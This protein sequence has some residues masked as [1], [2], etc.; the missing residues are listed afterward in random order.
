AGWCR[1]CL[2]HDE[3]ELTAGHRLLVEARDGWGGRGGELG[4]WLRAAALDLHSARGDVQTARELAGDLRSG[5]A[6]LAVAAARTELRA[7]DPRAAELLMPDWTAASAVDWPIAV[8]LDA[9]LLATVLAGRAGDDRR[10][11]R[12]LEQALDLAAPDGYRRPFLRAEPGLRELL[13]AH[14]DSGTAH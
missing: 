11:G 13:A 2:R 4:S 12:L 9:A 5:A 7:G 1:A 6:A 10:A 8:R 3:G 14:L